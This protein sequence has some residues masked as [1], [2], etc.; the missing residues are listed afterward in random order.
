MNL[1]VL[2]ANSQGI[3]FKLR[4]VFWYSI[5]LTSALLRWK[6]P[7]SPT[8]LSALVFG[9]NRQP[10]PAWLERELFGCR[11]SSAAQQRCGWTLLCSA[12]T[13]SAFCGLGGRWVA[14]HWNNHVSQRQCCH[15]LS[16]THCWNICNCSQ[17]PRC[18]ISKYSN[19]KELKD[20]FRRLFL[21]NWWRVS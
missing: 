18:N 1:A 20:C 14:T 9:R 5:A 4:Q 13:S 15:L 7:E 10:V 17:K 3:A 6:P 21:Q 12:F 11:G 19:K 8:P 16:I 2:I